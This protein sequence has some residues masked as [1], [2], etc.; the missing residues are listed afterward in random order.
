MDRYLTPGDLAKR[1]GVPVGTVYDWNS[2]R[3]GP[4]YIRVGRH[5]RYVPADV[6]SWE[7]SRYADHRD[8]A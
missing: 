1:Y 8:A 6:A 5:V 4:R 3:T 2:Q 7:E